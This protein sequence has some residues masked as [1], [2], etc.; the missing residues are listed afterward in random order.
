MTD[1]KT[2]KES[3]KS[4]EVS[5]SWHAMTS[6]DVLQE[7]A[8]PPE[9]GLSSEEVKARQ[10]KFGLN[11]LEEA[12]SHHFL[13]DALGTDQQLCDLY[14]ACRSDYFSPIGRLH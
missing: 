4:K 11:E 12:P 3:I 9:E 1:E 14:A 7:L 2:A 6:T 5:I 13:G 8:T 10:A